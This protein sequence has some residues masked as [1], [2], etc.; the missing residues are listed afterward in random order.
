MKR[1]GSILLATFAFQ[2]LPLAQADEI[3]TNPHRT[4]GFGSQFQTIIYSVIYAELNNK[5]YCYTPFVEM[6]H[7]YDND[8][9]FIKK[10]EKL[11]N[12]IDNFEINKDLSIQSIRRDLDFIAFF[13]DNLI[14]CANSSSLKKIKKN[15]LLN[16]Y[17][18]DY[19]NSKNLNIAVHI[20][21]P[22]PHDSRILGTNA[23]DS[24][25][26]KI[27]DL[28]RELYSSKSPLFHIYSQGNVEAFNNIF[29]ADDIVFHIN[30]SIEQSFTALVLAD[31]L[32][33]STSS[34]S[35]TAGILSE[36]VVYYFPFWH[37]PLPNWIA[38][39]V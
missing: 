23:P 3:V 14:A 5:Q 4:D 15:F 2:G 9:D 25:Y 6:E 8:V 34:F 11:I 13:E 1:I 10:K 17:K 39:D 21:R 37:P 38:I 29:N 30:E 18:E 24:V 19:F 28:L 31:V 35:Y 20:R 26:I 27:I 22:N 7:N 32:V 36:G 16:K 12:F 33:T